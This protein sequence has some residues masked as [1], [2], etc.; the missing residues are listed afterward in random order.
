MHRRHLP[1]P[2]LQDCPYVSGLQS[3]LSP[4]QSQSARPAV[5]QFQTT[6]WLRPCARGPEIARSPMTARNPLT[7]RSPLATRGPVAAGRALDFRATTQPAISS[8]ASRVPTRGPVAAGQVPPSRAMT[9]P[10]PS[11]LASN[12]PT[13]GGLHASAA[14]RDSPSGEDQCPRTRQT[15]FHC[16]LA[17][18]RQHLPG[19]PLLQSGSASA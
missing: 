13:H 10:V 1:A 4:V 9:Q 3:R 11:L 12:L 2:T 8:L 15:P 18:R 17:L 5:L 14:H 16:W 19:C 7:A 6:Q